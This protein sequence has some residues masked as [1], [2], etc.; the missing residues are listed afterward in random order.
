MLIS[1]LCNYYD[2]LAANGAFEDESLVEQDVSYMVFLNPD[3]AVA[4]IIDYTEEVPIKTKKGTKIQR[5][6]RKIKVPYHPNTTSVVAYL[7]DYRSEY[8]FGFAKKDPKKIQDGESLFYFYTKKHDA[9]VKTNLEFIEGINSPIVNAYR[10]FL[11]NW[12]PP[13]QVEGTIFQQVIGSCCCFALE[14][15][16]EIQLQKDS[17]LLKKCR[18]R[19]QNRSYTG[20]IGTCAITGL[21]GQTIAELHNSIRGI[22]GGQPSGTKLVCFNNPSD[23]SYGKKQSANSSISAAAA[24]KYTGA[25]NW[26]LRTDGHHTNLDD[27]T[28]VYWADT[29]NADADKAVCDV[30]DFFC[31]GEKAD[32]AETDSRLSSFMAKARVGELSASDLSAEGIDPSVSFY[33]VGLTPNSSRISVKFVYRNTVGK[34]AENI[35]QHQ[36]DLMHSGIGDSKMYLGLLVRELFSPKSSA[37]NPSYPMYASM[38][39]SILNGTRYPGSLLSTVVLRCKTD[40][41]DKGKKSDTKVIKDENAANRTDSND[42]RKRFYAINARRIALIK[43]CL[44]RQA[45]IMNKQEVIPMALDT[46]NNSQAYVCGRLF[47][48]LEY[49]QKCAN[50][51]SSQ[52]DF[53]RTANEVEEKLD[54][55]NQ[56]NSPKELNRTIKDSYFSSACTRPAVVFP[57]LMMLAQHHLEKAENGGYINGLIR[58][59]V[60]K[61]EG[62]FPSTLDPDEQ[63]EFIVGYYQQNKKL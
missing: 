61:L 43:A 8:I 56:K 48:L 5:N 12:K 45:R 37:K 25:L 47:A 11:L 3:G 54:E 53:N 18:E 33:V 42:K 49:A 55:Q 52:K 29:E 21:T 39:E 51:K 59:T 26:L 19:F 50:Q 62:K 46:E 34:F 1:A 6:K 4:D 10:E 36:H 58:E 14:G 2:T 60:D 23:E 28:L 27:M 15:H 31:T 57:R 41:D 24:E 17:L 40:S 38:M 22:R 20:P 63:G 44:N 35:A 16:P 9:F 30:F 7:L 32:R 13:E